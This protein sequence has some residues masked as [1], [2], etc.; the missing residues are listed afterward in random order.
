MSKETKDGLT[1][2]DIKQ[3]QLKLDANPPNYKDKQKIRSEIIRR[4]MLER[5][6]WSK[7]TNNPSNNN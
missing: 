2:E 7:P 4:E 1:L 3:H 6:G 5:L